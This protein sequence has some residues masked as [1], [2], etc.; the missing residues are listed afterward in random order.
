MLKGEGVDEETVGGN[1]GNNRSGEAEG[2]GGRPDVRQGGTGDR[3]GGWRKVQSRGKRKRRKEEQRRDPGAAPLWKSGFTLLL[4]LPPVSA[5]L[6][7]PL[8]SPLR[9]PSL[10]SVSRRS[11]R[12]ICFLSGFFPSPPSLSLSLSLSHSV[13]LS[14]STRA[15]RDPSRFPFA[16]EPG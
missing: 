10:S 8:E 13:S 11:S 14:L 3:N 7:L 1:K 16:G 6:D 9:R 2:V 15:R 12:R 4:R 5:A